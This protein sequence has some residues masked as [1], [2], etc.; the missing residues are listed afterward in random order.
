MRKLSLVFAMLLL[1][2]WARFARAADGDF[3]GRWDVVVHKPPA[4]VLST[5]TKAWWLGIAGAGTP[6]LKV[7]F[8]GSPDGGLDNIPNPKIEEG[9]C[10]TSGAAPAGMALPLKSIMKRR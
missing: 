2:V 4:Q 7:Q 6:D 1:S 3:N 8:V 5:T 9:C 10:A